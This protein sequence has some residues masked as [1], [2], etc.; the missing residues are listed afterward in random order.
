MTEKHTP[1]SSARTKAASKVELKPVYL[2]PTKPAMTKEE[3]EAF[4][5][6]CGGHPATPEES[7]MFRKFIK[8]PYP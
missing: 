5:L 8:D 1:A 2:N 3:V 6:S 4:I 7:R